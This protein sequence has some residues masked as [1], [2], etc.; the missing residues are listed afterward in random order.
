M[1][2]YHSVTYALKKWGYAVI[3]MEVMCKYMV[4]YV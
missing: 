3:R 4:E 2:N 1:M